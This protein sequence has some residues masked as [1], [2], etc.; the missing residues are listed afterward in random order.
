MKIH[1]IL[2]V[3]LPALL[4]SIASAQT[5]WYVDIHATPPGNGTLATPFTSIQAAF[6]NP[7]MSSGST[8]FVAPGVYK[9][10]L[11]YPSK[12]VG[13][14]SLSGPA[15]T[16]IEPDAPT[17]SMGSIIDMGT[18]VRTLVGF[19]IS[20]ARVACS[21]GVD[22]Q[23]AH[24][25]YCVITGN[26]QGSVSPTFSGS[27]VLT[28]GD[29]YIDNCT[30]S[31]NAKGTGIVFVGAVYART[32]IVQG[33]SVWDLDPIT[34]ST[35]STNDYTL[36][37]GS[38]PSGTGNLSGN[39]LFWDPTGGDFHLKPLSPCINT[40]DPASPPDPDGSRA[41]MGAF[42]YDPNYVPGPIVY[43]TAKVNSQ[44]CIPSISASGASSA[45]S[46]SGFVVS[47]I[48]ELNNKPGIYIYSN[49]GRAAVPFSGGLLC[50]NSPIRRSIPL[51]S[52]GNP[53]PNDCSGSYALDFNAYAVGALGG[54]P[55]SFLTVPGTLVDC[56][57]WARDNGFPP[58]D[59][60]SLSNAIE[61]TIAP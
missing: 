31:K 9:E 1:S 49:T 54:N 15:V 12:V 24:L 27:A 8:V 40:G 17:V 56:Q 50:V 33:N 37:G 13:L 2:R 52:G 6:T 26:K 46:G 5:T 35:I 58:P 61:W 28:H 20:G 51:N 29:L 7:A 41:D 45:S 38:V 36:V 44:S 30:L 11:V 53:P 22:G 48:N 39:P 59:N 57:A 42:A 3:F 21:I 16:W 4:A 14:R 25:S 18:A 10:T 47:A 55:A 23:N 43:C 34:P 60:A 32:S 19:T